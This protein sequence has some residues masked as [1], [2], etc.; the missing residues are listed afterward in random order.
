MRS[1]AWG[2][3]RSTPLSQGLPGISEASSC[4]RRCRSYGSDCA[5][6]EAWPNCQKPLWK[7]RYTD[8]WRKPPTT[9]SVAHLRVEPDPP[10]RA[11]LKV[12]CSEI[13][14]T[15]LRCPESV[16]VLS[17]SYVLCAQ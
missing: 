3:G 2:A 1:C 12:I 6:R 5:T 10:P 16:A 14:D 8:A 11:M 7:A 15:R 17:D 13:R 9:Y 4:T